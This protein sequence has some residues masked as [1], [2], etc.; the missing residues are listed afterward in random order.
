[1]N[2]DYDS[3]F[4]ENCE[5]L[6]YFKTTKKHCHSEEWNDEESPRS[7]QYLKQVKDIFDCE[8]V[9]KEDTGFRKK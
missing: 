9:R 3:F 5:T 4:E 8:T 1:M 2:L 7:W 6:T